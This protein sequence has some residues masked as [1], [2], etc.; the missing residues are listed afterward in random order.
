[1][2]R[3][4]R[5]SMPEPQLAEFLDDAAHASGRAVVEI[6]VLPA[7]DDAV[8]PIGHFGLHAGANWVPQSQP[9]KGLSVAS[10]A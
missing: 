1:M 9:R 7:L 10:V 4:L 2:P 5:P 6:T 8:E 3:P